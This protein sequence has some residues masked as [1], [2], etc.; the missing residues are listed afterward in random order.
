MSQDK[1]WTPMS[2]FEGKTYPQISKP[3]IQECLN[4]IEDYL[5]AGCK[6]TRRA[7]HLK[8]KSIYKRHY[9]EEYKNK[10]EQP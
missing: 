6:E 3:T 5:N 4:V 2:E 1:E 8:A 10:N 7:A 9:G